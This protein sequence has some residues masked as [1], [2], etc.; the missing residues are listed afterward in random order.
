[1]KKPNVSQFLKKMYDK[2]NNDFWAGFAVCLGVVVVAFFGHMAYKDSRDLPSGTVLDYEIVE[3]AVVGEKMVTLVNSGTLKAYPV[4]IEFSK[5]SGNT[6]N[7]GIVVN[8]D[9]L[10]KKGDRV[11]IF[12]GSNYPTMMNTF[13][14]VGSVGDLYLL[15]FNV[16][17]GKDPTVQQGAVPFAPDTSAFYAKKSDVHKA[18]DERRKDPDYVQRE[19]SKA[20]ALANDALYAEAQKLLGEAK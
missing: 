15:Q 7:T 6:L 11:Q 1:M 17:K 20:S 13:T 9:L 8:R 2:S 18:L 12:P 16:L 3:K 5:P 4:V 10:L 19:M 14:V